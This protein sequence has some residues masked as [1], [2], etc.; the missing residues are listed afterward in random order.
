MG[1]SPCPGRG[2][3]RH[4]QLSQDVCRVL[5]HASAFGFVV[6]ASAGFP[7]EG[8]TTSRKPSGDAPLELIQAFKIGIAWQGNPGHTNDQQRSIPLVSFEPLARLDRVRLFSV[9]KGPGTD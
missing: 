9:Q 7:P 8:G 4:D 1:N 5:S 2:A 3:A 6:P